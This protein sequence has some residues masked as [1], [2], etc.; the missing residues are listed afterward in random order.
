VGFRQPDGL[1]AADR[2]AYA[3]R[4]QQVPWNSRL[5]RV[6]ADG[7]HLGWASR[8]FAREYLAPLIKQSEAA[9]PLPAEYVE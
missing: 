7:S 1:S 5:K 8:E 6:G 9:Q 3:E 2:A 4:L